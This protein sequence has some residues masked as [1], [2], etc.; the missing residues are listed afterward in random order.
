MFP[1]ELFTPDNPVRSWTY[2]VR[3]SAHVTRK[4]NYATKLAA[5]ALQIPPSN[6][7]RH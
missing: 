4:E 2:P 7:K 3:L 5:L 6:K 1:H